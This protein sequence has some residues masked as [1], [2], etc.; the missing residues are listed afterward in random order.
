MGIITQTHAQNV[1]M[2][3]EQHGVMV[4]ACGRVAAVYQ[5]NIDFAFEKVHILSFFVYLDSNIHLINT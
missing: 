4:T 3:M 5:V 2:E 1:L